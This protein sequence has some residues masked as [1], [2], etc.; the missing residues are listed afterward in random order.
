[1]HK[2]IFDTVTLSNFILADSVNVLINMY[3]N[4]IFITNEIFLE[5]EISISKGFNKIKIINELLKSR[6]I[7]KIILNDDEYKFTLD[8]LNNLGIGEASCIAAAKS[9]NAVV[10][11]DDRMARSVCMEN[12][13]LVTGTIGILKSAVYSKELT[14][15]T[16]DSILN[17]MIENG[18]YAPVSRISDVL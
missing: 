10:V 13:L 1:M 7:N 6:E 9:R 4:N 8:L 3:K 18:Y 14:L 5:L 12:K 2:Y 11:T 17:N 15:Q 16:A